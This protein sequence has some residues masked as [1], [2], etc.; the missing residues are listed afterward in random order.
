MSGC[1]LGARMGEL[2]EQLVNILFRTQ[3]QAGE[4]RI[5][6]M[7]ALET[8]GLLCRLNALVRR[9]QLMTMFVQSYNERPTLFGRQRKQSRF[10]LFNA[11]ASKAI[12]SGLDCE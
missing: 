7:E 2:G 10:Q 1:L 5:R 4:V 12:L 6:F 9:Q 3:L 8:F 11:H